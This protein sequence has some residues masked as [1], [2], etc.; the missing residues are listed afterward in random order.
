MLVNVWEYKHTYTLVGEH[1]L[2]YTFEMQFNSMYQYL[3]YIF[4][5]NQ[6]FYFQEHSCSHLYKK[7]YARML[8]VDDL[9]KNMERT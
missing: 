3:K 8:T 4:P 6:Q 5:L 2:E 9:N 7:P 1:S